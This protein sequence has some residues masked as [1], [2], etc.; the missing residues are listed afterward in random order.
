MAGISG[1]NMLPEK[2]GM[3]APT[4]VSHIQFLKRLKRG[5]EDGEDSSDATPEPSGLT[6]PQTTTA[7]PILKK[8]IKKE[9]DAGRLKTKAGGASGDGDQKR[10]AEQPNRGGA[11]FAKQQQEDRSGAEHAQ[12]SHPVAN[13]G[14]HHH[15]AG[16][17]RRP[18]KKATASKIDRDGEDGGARPRKKLG[19]AQG[20]ASERRKWPQADL[21]PNDKMG[22]KHSDLLRTQQAEADTAKAKAAM[23]RQRRM[24]KLRARRQATG[25]LSRL[26]A[27]KL[28]RLALAD[29]SRLKRNLREQLRR[30]NSPLIQQSQ[31]RSR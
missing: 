26:A 21:T 15:H 30:K 6:E 19:G 3:A 5:L 7:G 1:G 16:D 13:G 28:K 12:T 18:M 8:R 25:E 22:G 23:R 14:K 27:V 31:Q 11:R 4:A 24:Q 17:E 10:T 9:E 20:A 29:A 2:P